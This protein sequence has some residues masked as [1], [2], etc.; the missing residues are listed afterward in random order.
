MTDVEEIFARLAQS[1][2]RSRIHLREKE[3]DYL[4]RKGMET[5]L[6]HAA[7]FVEKRLGAASPANDGKQTPWRNHPV[8]V[9]QH[10]TGTCCRSCLEKW[11]AIPKGRELTEEEKCHVVQVIG[12]WLSIESS[13]ESG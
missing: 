12:R 7:D 8:F 3:R 9:A 1:D 13:I 10:A 6:R 2:F 11:H 4:T 5:V